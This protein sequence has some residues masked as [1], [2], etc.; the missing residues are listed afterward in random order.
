V[1]PQPNEFDEHRELALAMNLLSSNNWTHARQTLHA[2]AAKIPQSKQYRALL[3]YTRGREAQAN[4]RTEEAQLEF[5]RALQL[6]PE[7]AMAKQALSELTRRR[8]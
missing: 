7:L 4:G 5:Q 2:L 3:C 6:D 1:S 8:W